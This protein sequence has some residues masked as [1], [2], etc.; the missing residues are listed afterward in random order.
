MSQS[1]RTPSN[2]S[3]KIGR[4]NGIFKRALGFPSCTQKIVA[5]SYHNRTADIRWAI[6]T[7][8]RLSG[9]SFHLHTLLGVSVCIS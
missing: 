5:S 3:S 7:C 4:Y 6:D 8:S 9:R 2:T 1:K